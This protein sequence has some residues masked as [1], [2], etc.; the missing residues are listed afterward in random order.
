MSEELRLAIDP[1]RLS[2]EVMQAYR[3]LSAANGHQNWWPG[4]T[5]IEIITGAILTQNTS[6]TNVEKAIDQLQNYDL[7][8]VPGLRETPQTVLAQIIRAAG[9]YRQKAEKLKAFIGWLDEYYDGDLDNVENV[10]TD[11]LRPALLS[12]WGIGP[13]TAD[14]ILLYAFNRPVFVVDT[15]TRRIAS[16]HDWVSSTVDYDGLQRC[17]VDHLPNDVCLYNDYHAQIVMT[18]KNFCGTKPKCDNCPLAKLL[19]KIPSE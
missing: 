10:P 9:Y 19:G 8:T 15:Y 6:W 12:V 14:S 16:R 3:I 4:E 17:F 2:S 1:N 18:G 5:R 13:E 7:L 11:K